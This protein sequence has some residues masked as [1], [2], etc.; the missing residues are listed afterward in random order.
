MRQIDLA[1]AEDVGKLADM[2]CTPA[3][4]KSAL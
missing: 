1:A 3:L 4:P 2:A